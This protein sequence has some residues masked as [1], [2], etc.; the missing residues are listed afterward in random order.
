MV[1]PLWLQQYSSKIFWL[2]F[3]CT[4]LQLGKYCDGIFRHVHGRQVPS[5][6]EKIQ[7]GIHKMKF[8]W[9]VNTQQ[10]CMMNLAVEKNSRF[11]LLIKFLQKF[12]NVIQAL[13]STEF[14]SAFKSSNYCLICGPT[15]SSLFLS[16]PHFFWEVFDLNSRTIRFLYPSTSQIFLSNGAW[17]LA[18]VNRFLTY[19]LKQDVP[20]SCDLAL[21]LNGEAIFLIR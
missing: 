21:F 12:S 1:S 11:S 10:H 15:K 9:H 4:F 13:L 2:V 5:F 6:Q 16:C 18:E 20:H 8:Q 19:L 3:Q 7:M 17:Y 14:N